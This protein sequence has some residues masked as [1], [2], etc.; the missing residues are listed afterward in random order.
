MKTLHEIG[1]ASRLP[2]DLL[3]HQLYT[4]EIESARFDD[5][6]GYLILRSR[7]MGTQDWF[8]L[9]YAHSGWQERDLQTI[10]TWSQGNNLRDY[11]R[12]AFA[13]QSLMNG[14]VE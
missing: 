11:Y 7:I 12:L 8:D 3:Q 6:P 10:N 13:G 5:T 2:I 9:R 14:V 1:P 4:I